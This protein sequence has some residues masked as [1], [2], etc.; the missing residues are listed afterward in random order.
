MEPQEVRM[1]VKAT[2]AI[3]TCEEHVYTRRFVRGQK[4][5]TELVNKLQATNIFR[6]IG[7]RWYLTY[8]HSS[9][10]A[11]SDAA[12]AALKQG[13]DK[14]SSKKSGK[15][16][17][18][19]DDDEG[20]KNILGA[21]NVGPELGDAKPESEEDSGQKRVIMGSLSDLLNGSFGDILGG[22]ED[23]ESSNNG[24]G[25]GDPRGEDGNGIGPN[26]AIIFR[27]VDD[28]DGDE[29][30]DEDDDDA[31][32]KKLKRFAKAVDKSKSS[33]PSKHSLQQDCIGLLRKLTTE[34]RIS[35]NQ[36]R[37]LLTDIISC[38]AKGD[39]SMVEVSY[40]LLVAES[41]DGDAAEEEFADQCRAFAEKTYE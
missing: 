37:V 5:K 7:G 14:E 33:S 31:S 38:A 30:D 25:T 2:T 16:A 10:H 12:K 13:G 20:I 27:N 29:D 15:K 8:H 39:Y 19:D 26:K 41:A 36:K 1:T 6:K 32:A 3:V 35:Q 11:D 9:W 24:N 28:I 23:D 17:D 4:R 22:G 21:K 40:E 34:G 18:E